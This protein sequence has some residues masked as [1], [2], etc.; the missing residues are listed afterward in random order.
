MDE[1]QGLG[2][3]DAGNTDDRRVASY[4]LFFVALAMSLM[5]LWGAWTAQ[6]EIVKALLY[7]GALLMGST[8][9]EKFGGK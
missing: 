7:S 1:K 8:V 9:A 3:D 6:P 2:K 4:A 5:D